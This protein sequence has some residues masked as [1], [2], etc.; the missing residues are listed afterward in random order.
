MLNTLFLSLKQKEKSGIITPYCNSCKCVLLTRVKF[1]CVVVFSNYYRM[2]IFSWIVVTVCLSE[3]L[4]NC[5]LPVERRCLDHWYLDR[6]YLVYNGYMIILFTSGIVKCIWT[7]IAKSYY[8][9]T[10]TL[11]WFTLYHFDWF[12][13]ANVALTYKTWTHF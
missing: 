10:I 9:Y 4:G 1:C 11:I 6:W 8:R 13:I 2:R 7:W 12:K 3:V 5:L